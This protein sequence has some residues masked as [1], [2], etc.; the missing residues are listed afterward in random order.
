MSS[1]MTFKELKI[2]QSDLINSLLTHYSEE[3]ATEVANR[4]LSDLDSLEQLEEDY[5]GERK[6]GLDS[7]QERQFRIKMR[8]IAE[9]PIKR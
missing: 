7:E 5:I 9:L 3:R 6:K 1:R 4:I 2:K 8:R